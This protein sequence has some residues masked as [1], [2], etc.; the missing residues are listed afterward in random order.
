M[1]IGFDF[2]SCLATQRIQSVAKRFIDDGHDVW[3]VTTRTATPGPTLHWDNVNLFK[4]AKELQIPKEKIVFTEG[5]DKHTFLSGFDIFFDDC[6]IE[7]DLIEENVPEC[8][9][10]LITPPRIW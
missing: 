7:I 5:K 9:V 6:E 10:I 1:K 2:D 4:I 8:A 3:I